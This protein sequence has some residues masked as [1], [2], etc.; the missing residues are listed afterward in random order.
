MEYWLF[1]SSEVLND[2]LRG[3]NYSAEE[4]D[5]VRGKK[6]VF[7]REGRLTEVID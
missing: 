3:G 2:R 1:N 5:W 6:M 4:K 7:G